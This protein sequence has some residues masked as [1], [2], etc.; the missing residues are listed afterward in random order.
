[1]YVDVDFYLVVGIVEQVAKK[2]NIPVMLFCDNA[3]RREAVQ[4]H[5]DSERRPALGFRQGILDE[6]LKRYIVHTYRLDTL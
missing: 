1:M 2:N 3:A 6:L 5:Q 4:H